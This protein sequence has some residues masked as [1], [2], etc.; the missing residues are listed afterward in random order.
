MTFCYFKCAFEQLEKD[1]YLFIYFSS[2]RE[3]KAA[4]RISCKDRFRF[5]RILHLRFVESLASVP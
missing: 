4:A 5:N 1:I 2:K 3:E